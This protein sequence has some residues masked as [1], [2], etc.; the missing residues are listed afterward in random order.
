MPKELESQ[1]DRL[2]ANFMSNTAPL[3]TYIHLDG[4]LSRLQWDLIQT[5]ITNFQTFLTDWEDRNGRP[6]R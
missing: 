6:E 5:T 3:G 4:S 2:I 1:V